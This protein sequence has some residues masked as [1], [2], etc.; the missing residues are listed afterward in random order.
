MD[1]QHH[2]V[3]DIVAMNYQRYKQVQSWT[4]S[5]AMGT[6][7]SL[8]VILKIFWVKLYSSNNYISKSDSIDFIVAECGAQVVEKSLFKLTPNFKQT[9]KSD[10]K[11][12]NDSDDVLF[13]FGSIEKDW[14]KEALKLAWPIS[15]LRDDK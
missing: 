6:S 13:K 10:I 5:C 8:K 7:V 12:E 14:E 11:T 1:Y 9:V 4:V 2:T 3:I 15:D